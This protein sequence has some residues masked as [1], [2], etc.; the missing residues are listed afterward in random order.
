MCSGALR[1]RWALEY[2]RPKA[3]CFTTFDNSPE[4][5][6][7]NRSEVGGWVTPPT[8]LV[9][10]FTLTLVVGVY[11]AVAVLVVARRRPGYEHVRHTISELGE[12]G[13]P[14]QT[15]VSIGVFLPVGIL[16]FVV[17]YLLCPVSEPPAMLALCVAV[18]Y[19][20]AAAFPCDPGSPL[21]GSVRQAVHN[22]GGFVEYAGGAIALLRLAETLGPRFRAA[23]FIG[24]GALVGLSFSGPLRGL[25]QRVAEAALFAGL[26]LAVWI[27]R[28]AA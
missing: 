17:A 6:T 26:S 1:R 5:A 9:L 13:A 14:D 20:V 7:S 28:V 23:G 3:A 2:T 22:A 15:L 24:C 27:T 21:S 8:L 4:C 10:S 19:L 12:I 11:L 16:L 18:G 25:I